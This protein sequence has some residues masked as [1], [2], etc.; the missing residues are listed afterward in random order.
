VGIDRRA[1]VGAEVA[2]SDRD[3]RFAVARQDI[4]AQE[5]TRARQHETARRLGDVGRWREASY[6]RPEPR[7]AMGMREE[8]QTVAPGAPR[9]SASEDI[10]ARTLTCPLTATRGPRPGGPTGVSVAMRVP[11]R[12]PRRRVRENA[13]RRR[14]TRVP[15]PC[16]GGASCDRYG[17]E[18]RGSR[19]A[20]A[21][22]VDRASNAGRAGPQ[23]THRHAA[24]RVRRRLLPTC[25]HRR[26][27]VVSSKDQCRR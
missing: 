18:R 9:S 3:A 15:Q 26:R 12:S 27:P 24:P 2:Q 20:I 11:Q 7:T 17:T 22:H 5:T 19:G 16:R 21:R 13:P 25:G 10:G 4:P 8:R 1:V 6:G 14:H 23:P